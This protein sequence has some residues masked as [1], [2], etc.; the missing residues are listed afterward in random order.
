MTIESGHIRR[1]V[2]NTYNSTESFMVII[3]QYNAQC[4][5]ANQHFNAKFSPVSLEKRF[6]CTSFTPCSTS[7]LINPLPVFNI[8]FSK[9]S[10]VA[11][12]PAHLEY[13][14]T[15][16]KYLF[17]PWRIYICYFKLVFWFGKIMKS[18]MV[19]VDSNSFSPSY[20]F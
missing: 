13:K 5:Q 2:G 8:V 20:N 3:F 4:F 9:L 15:F 16:Q 1:I 10:E 11:F 18:Q 14:S 17:P 7:C 19:N 6:F 12:L